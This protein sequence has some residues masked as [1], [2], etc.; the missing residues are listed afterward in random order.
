MVTIRG[1]MVASKFVLLA[2]LA[3]TTT[4]AYGDFDVSLAMNL[5]CLI[6]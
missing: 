2:A 1:G 6:S 3:L 5:R 4:A